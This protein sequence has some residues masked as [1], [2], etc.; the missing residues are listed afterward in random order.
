MKKKK[1]KMEIPLARQRQKDGCIHC[2]PALET[3]DMLFVPRRATARQNQKKKR[4]EQA[5]LQM[6]RETGRSEWHPDDR[7]GFAPIRLLTA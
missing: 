1:K 6:Q 4:H 2:N 5:A 3:P 7:F